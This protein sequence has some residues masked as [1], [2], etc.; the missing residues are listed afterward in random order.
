FPKTECECK[1]NAKQFEDR[2]NFPNVLGAVDGKHIKVVPPPDSGSYFY[3]YKEYNN[4]VLMAIANANYEF[5]MVDFG[6]N[7]R[8]SA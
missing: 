3:N 1:T 7:D 5:V 4:M 6:I 2:W 8:N